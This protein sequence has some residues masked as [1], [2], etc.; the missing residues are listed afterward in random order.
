M[1]QAVQRAGRER[2]RERERERARETD[3]ERRWRAAQALSGVREHGLA[4]TQT[5]VPAT[6]DRGVA[7][8]LQEGQFDMH[9]RRSIRLQGR[10]RHE[11]TRIQGQSMLIHEIPILTDF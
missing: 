1:C 5:G 10:P 3:R 6:A 2:E 8:Q 4:A 11:G 9:P 7:A